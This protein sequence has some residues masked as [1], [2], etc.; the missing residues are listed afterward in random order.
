MQNPA[1]PGKTRK[2]LPKKKKKVVGACAVWKAVLL[3]V[4]PQRIVHVDGALTAGFETRSVGRDGQEY[5]LIIATSAIPCAGKGR[6]VETEAGVRE[7]QK[8][9]KLRAELSGR[10]SLVWSKR[11]GMRMF[12]NA[13]PPAE[14]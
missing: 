6:R 1:N 5:D 4:A 13:Q 12:T 10:C 3:S 14:L 8:G 2:E 11:T 9:L 7:G